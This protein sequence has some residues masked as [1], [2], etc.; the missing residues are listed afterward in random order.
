MQFYLYDIAALDQWDI[1]EDGQYG[2][3][4][5]IESFWIVDQYERFFI[6]VDEVLAGFVLTSHKFADGNARIHVVSEFFVLRRYRRTGVGRII[7]TRL[8]EEVDGTW[9]ILVMRSNTPA[10][11]FWATIISDHI[12]K[13][14]REFTVSQDK[15]DEVVFRFNA[16]EFRGSPSVSS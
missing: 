3:P 13:G 5:R 6:R 1:R 14:H 15:D 4:E 10:Q 16:A 2:N 7:A 11:K 9:E 8:F 12:G